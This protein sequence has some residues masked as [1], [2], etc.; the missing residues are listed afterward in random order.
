MEG[1]IGAA[2]GGFETQR[3]R[4][5]AGRGQNL[6]EGGRIEVGPLERRIQE[7]LVDLHADIAIAEDELEEDRDGVMHE[8]HVKDDG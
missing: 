8:F 2:V 6:R 4:S 1:R 3:K 5:Q 7:N